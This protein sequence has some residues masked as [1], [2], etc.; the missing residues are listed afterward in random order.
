ML[1]SSAKLS[2]TVY[3]QKGTSFKSLALGQPDVL[4]RAMVLKL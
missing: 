3:L 4:E 1:F 2:A